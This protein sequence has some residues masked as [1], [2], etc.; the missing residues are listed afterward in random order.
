MRPILFVILCVALSFSANSQFSLYKT[1][2]GVEFYTKWGNEKWWS[3]KSSKVLLVK[4][5]NTNSL[6][7]RYHL[8]VEFFKDMKMVEESKV[9]DYC[10]DQYSTAKARKRGLVFKPNEVH[11]ATL[12]SFELSGLKVEKLIAYECSEGKP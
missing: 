5:K 7:V 3:K 4:V 11:P 1:V 9:E 2:N 10:L 8:G 12:D 6:A